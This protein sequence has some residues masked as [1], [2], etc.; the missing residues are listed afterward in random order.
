MEIIRKYFFLNNSIK[1]ILSFGQAKFPICLEI[2]TV[3]IYI[4]ILG[5]YLF[6]FLTT[7]LLFLWRDVSYDRYAP[8]SFLQ[9]HK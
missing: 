3:Y 9:T 7:V 5:D 1:F 8:L 4:Y 6:Q 2:I